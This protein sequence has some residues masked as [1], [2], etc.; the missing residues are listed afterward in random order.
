MKKSDLDTS[1]ISIFEEIFPGDTNP[2]GTAFGGKI[3]ALVDRAAGLAA[4]RFARCNFV[5]A[6]LDT[7]EFRA[8]VKKGEIAEVVAQ[9]VYV[10]T[11]TCGVKVQVFALDKAHWDRR[12]CCVGTVFMVAIDADSKPQRVPSFEPSTDEEKKDWDKT[13]AIHR[14][15]LENRQEAT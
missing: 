8:A 2:Y 5:T 3:L 4:A 15:M 13:R 6:S 7:L 14:R 11:H 12:P 10:S 9:V 1:P